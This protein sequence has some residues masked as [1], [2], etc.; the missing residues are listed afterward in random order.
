MSTSVYSNRERVMLA[1]LTALLLTASAAHAHLP[2]LFGREYARVDESSS[3]PVQKP[4]TNAPTLPPPTPTDASKYAEQIR[5]MEVDTGAYAPGLSEAL[6]SLAQ[7]QWE[8]GRTDDAA[9]T[10]RRALQLIR[11]NEGLYSPGQ[12]PIL[13]QLMDLY[14]ETGGHAELGDLYGYYYRV[15]G[16][17]QEP[18][19]ATDLPVVHEYL[20][21]ER[22]LYAVRADDQAYR[23]LLRAYN[24][25]QTMLDSAEAASAEVYLPLAMSQL[26]N[27]YLIMGDRPMDGGHSSFSG[28]PTPEEKQLSGIQRTAYGKG[29]RLLQECLDRFPDLPPRDRAELYR[30][31]G[32]WQQW[33]GYVLR[34][35][36]QYAQVIALMREAGEEV[37]LASWFDEPVELPDI[38]E[39]WPL[40]EVPDPDAPDVVTASYEVT[41]RGE[42][43]G[44]EASVDGDEDAWPARKI[45]SMLRDSHFR[46][47]ISDEGP[48][49]GPRVTRRYRLLEASNQ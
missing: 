6:A 16:L 45:R 7:L 19:T 32:D 1:A 13:R 38:D 29:R 9:D 2:E 11:I 37:L 18:V 30:L 24:A 25:N 28:D 4:S 8:T 40:P 33:N 48:Q 14:R 49:N 21:W 44:L 34:S 15:S 27:L 35:A 22:E 41:R 36:Q 47:R 20:D 46:P 3:E 31:L 26:R 10:L 12:L 17:G 39:L 43:R 5:D 23:H 42:V